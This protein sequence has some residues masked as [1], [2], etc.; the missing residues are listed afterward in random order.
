MRNF[1]FS[2][3]A[4]EQYNEWQLDNKQIFNKFKKLIKETAKSPFEGTEARA[5][6]TS[7]YWVLVA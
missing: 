2:S 7:L 3:I 6:E 4:F 5:L 1:L